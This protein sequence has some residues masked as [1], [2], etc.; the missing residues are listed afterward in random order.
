M[1][2][3]LHNHSEYSLLDGLTKVKDMA[4]RARDLGMPAIAITDHGNM[5]GYVKF[6]NACQEQGIKPIIGC[7][8]YVVK[9]HALKGKEHKQNWHLIVLAKNYTGLQNMFRMLKIANVEGYYFRP[10]IDINLLAQH[11]EGLIVLSACLKGEVADLILQDK[12]TE[13]LN[14][15]QLYKNIFGEDY[16][17]EIQRHEG[18]EFEKIVQGKLDISKKL[19]IKV[20]ATTDSHYPTSDMADAQGR[21][22][23]ISTGDKLRMRGSDYCIHH[24]DHM[25]DLF[26]DIPEA[27]D[28]TL[29]IYQKIESFPLARPLSIPSLGIKNEFSVL[30]DRVTKEA[31][32]KYGLPLPT[33]YQSRLDYELD[34]IQ[35]TKFARYI[36]LVSDITD[37]ATRSGI[38]FGPRGSA[39]GSLIC[40][41]LGISKAD[42]IKHGLVFERFLNPARIEPPDIDIDFAHDCRD[43]IV[44]YLQNKYGTDHVG[45]I[46]TFGTMKAKQAIKDMARLRGMDFA[47]INSI[48]AGISFKA[49]L[50]D[51]EDLEN[52]PELKDIIKEAK[53]LEGIHRH[54]STHAAGIVLA[55]EPL[56]DLV[57]VE[58]GAYESLQVQ[59]EMTDLEQI[60]LM[61][62]DILGIDSLSVIRKALEN[63]KHRHDIDIDLWKLPTDDKLTYDMLSKGHVHG[64]FQ[65]GGEGMRNVTMQLKPNSIDDLMALVALY[66]P[67]PMDLIPS[68][69]AVR[70]SKQAPTYIHP[71]LEDILKPTHG[72]MIYQ[73]QVLQCLQKLAGYTYGE[74]DI[75]RKAIAKKKVDIINKEKPKFIKKAIANGLTQEEAESFWSYVEPFADYSFNK[76]HACSYAYLAYQSAYLKAHYPLEYIGALLE[77]VSDADDKVQAGITEAQALGLKV[78]PPQANFSGIRCSI[79]NDGI[80]LGLMNIKGIGE[81]VAK[82]VI[83][84]KP[85]LTFVDALDLHT[86]IGKKNLEHLV[87][88]GVFSSLKRSVMLDYI[89]KH[90]KAEKKEIPEGQLSLFDRKA[91]VKL[92]DEHIPEISLDQISKWEMEY[93]GRYIT[94]NPIDLARNDAGASFV[95]EINETGFVAGELKVVRFLVTKKDQ[96]PMA[97]GIITDGNADYNFVCFPK[98]YEQI[99]ACLVNG[100]VILATVTKQIRDDQLQLVISYAY[101]YQAKQTPGSF[102][103]QIENSLDQWNKAWKLALVHQGPHTV[104]F[105][106]R[107]PNREV[108]LTA[109]VNDEGIERLKLYGDLRAVT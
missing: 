7:E 25:K 80:L 35:K 66:R 70:E 27:L 5:Y 41:L 81:N 102:I 13:A 85:Y 28:N 99:K 106:L 96:K 87:K 39:G 48:T 63:I 43:K 16:Y 2:I 33:E 100:M 57:P 50:S 38:M 52:D 61:K 9:D 95:H 12:Q 92:P 109:S 20:V 60:G 78:L 90:L 55:G 88:A 29:E 103:L 76:A 6:F 1:Y 26:K 10:R 97:S 101:E 11:S 45:S 91:F 37:M 23:A 3:S 105:R 22:L 93:L 56:Q 54:K 14:T 77:I 69:I 36:L 18:D 71:M 75:I 72:I 73:E 68:F 44:A 40:H 53:E 24:P 30:K 4:A 49:K 89:D 108:M 84:N 58:K 34:I 46:V 98:I 67:G 32:N 74:A 79:H 42:P 31:H 94:N 47:A 65:L 8:F 64:V 62:I 104:Q 15:A 59:V 83:Q 51:L 82:R 17:L 107:N 21:L 86:K 19:G